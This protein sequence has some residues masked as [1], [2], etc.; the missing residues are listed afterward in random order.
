M[1]VHSLL[2]MTLCC[3]RTTLNSMLGVPGLSRSPV[4][5]RKP[6]LLYQSDWTFSYQSLIH[7]FKNLH[8]SSPK[9]ETRKNDSSRLYDERRRAS[10]ERQSGHDS[11]KTS[12]FLFVS[13]PSLNIPTDEAPCP[14]KH[15]VV[16]EGNLSKVP[17]VGTI[18]ALFNHPLSC[19]QHSWALTSISQHQDGSGQQKSKG[20]RFG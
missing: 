17:G 12:Y 18:F 11:T 16:F 19:I 6:N 13:F 9:E 8:S 15:E 14:H 20:L 4:V 3:D 2:E 10:S 7:I 5:L 1:I